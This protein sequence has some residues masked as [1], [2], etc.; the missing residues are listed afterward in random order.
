MVAST[1]VELVPA[2]WRAADLTVNLT[3]HIQA[4]FIV[5]CRNLG[6]LCS[7]SNSYVLLIKFKCCLFSYYNCNLN[8]IS[9]N[10]DTPRGGCIHCVS[11]GDRTWTCKTLCSQSICA[12]KLRHTPVNKPFRIKLSLTH[13]L[14]THSRKSCLSWSYLSTPRDIVFRSGPVRDRSGISRLQGS[15]FAT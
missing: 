12:T 10:Q 5:V 9:V 14:L 8:T 11:R 4:V 7:A 15:Y 13:Q 3:R 2:T 6:P 1:R